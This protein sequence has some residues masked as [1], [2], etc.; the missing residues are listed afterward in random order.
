MRYHCGLMAMVLRWIQYN[1]GSANDPRIAEGEQHAP[2]RR[3][4]QDTCAHPASGRSIARQTSPRRRIV[5][6]FQVLPMRNRAI[7]PAAAERPG[8]HGARDGYQARPEHV[9][10]RDPQAHILCG[11]TPVIPH[12]ADDRDIDVQEDGG[13]HLQQDRRHRE[14]DQQRLDREMTFITTHGRPTPCERLSLRHLQHSTC[15]STRSQQ[16][17]GRL[18]RDTGT[19]L[20]VLLVP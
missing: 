8:H 1:K 18:Q 16:T 11:Q 19:E 15:K 13:R 3:T 10:G 6:T 12:A 14:E 9:D 4:G 5:H 20:S 7:L 2:Q 17:I